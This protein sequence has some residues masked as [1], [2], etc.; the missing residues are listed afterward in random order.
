[1]K[2][3]KFQPLVYLFRVT[4]DN[5]IM[6][7]VMGAVMF[8]TFGMFY[9]HSIVQ[10]RAEE[11]SRVIRREAVRRKQPEKKRPE[12]WAKERNAEVTRYNEFV[13]PQLAY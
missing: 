6:N 10:V 11:S 12:S 13:N 7:A 2:A 3:L 9:A 8:T 4:W 1:M 5:H